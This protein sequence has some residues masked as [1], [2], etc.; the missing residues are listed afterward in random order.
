MPKFLQWPIAA[1]YNILILPMKLENPRVNIAH[2]LVSLG[3]T[4]NFPTPRG[5]NIQDTA[6]FMAAF[7]YGVKL[8]SYSHI[9]VPERDHVKLQV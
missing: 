1:Q 3:R 4:V 7:D 2:C 9:K 5:S 8:F 6:H